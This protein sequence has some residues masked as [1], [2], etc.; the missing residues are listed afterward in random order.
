MRRILRAKQMVFGV[1]LGVG[2]SRERTRSKTLST[3]FYNVPL[4]IGQLDVE[5]GLHV[6]Q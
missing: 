6:I 1:E 3:P 4:H 2:T 5:V